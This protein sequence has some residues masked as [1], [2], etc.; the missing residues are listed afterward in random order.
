MRKYILYSFSFVFLFALPAST[1]YEL[2]DYGFGSGGV[3]VTD[4]SLYSMNGILG[5]VSGAQN[6]GATYNL[7]P[8]LTF[9]RQ[10][11]TPA[12]PTFTNPANY[13]NRLRIVLDT[14]ANP[15]DTTF[16]IAISTDNFVTTNYVQADGTVGSSAVYQTYPAW[17]GVSGQLIVGLSPNT[18]YKTKT[19]AIQTKYNESALSAEASASTVGSSLSYDIDVS[20]TDAES[21]PPYS[22][23]IGSLTP[24]SVTTASDKIWIDLDTNAVGGGFVYVYNSGSGLQSSNASYTISSTT[25][26]LASAQEGYGARVENTTQSSGGPFTAESPYNSSGDTVGVLDMS[27]RTIFNSSSS[28]VTAGRGSILIKAKASTTTPAGGDYAS[29]LTMIASGAF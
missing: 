13:Y 21:A 27:T 26:N 8:G 18:T 2:H 22:L 20:S 15:S 4:S 10:A 16:A 24:G 11:N 12:A 9:A 1:T 25:G 6:V 23:N 14:G 5:E 3:G 17:G 19:R 28:P 29:I 7:G